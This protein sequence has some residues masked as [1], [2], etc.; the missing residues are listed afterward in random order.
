MQLVNDLNG[1]EPAGD[2][3]FSS[4]QQILKAT[5][6]APIVEAYRQCI[7][8]FEDLSFNLKNQEDEVL[9][10]QLRPEAVDEQLGRV[11]VWAANVGAH[12]EGKMSL[13][14]KLREASHIREKI[15]EM[16]VELQHS[17]NE[18]KL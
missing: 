13:D 15:I 9:K 1:Q 3:Q 17:L 14:H 12:R 2:N 4:N 5:A 6:A 16:L 18:S 10:L 7:I 8:S 11:R